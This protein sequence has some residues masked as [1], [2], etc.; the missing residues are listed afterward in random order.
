MA[1][2]I[3]QLA[4]SWLIIWLVEKQ[5]LNVLGFKPTKQRAA[6]FLLFLLVAA[7]CCASGFL[8][9]MWFGNERWEVNPK[10]NAAFVWEGIWWNIKSVLFEELIFR[11]VLFYILIK[12]VGVV[13]GIIVSSVAFGIYH[14]FSY[15]ILGNIP[16]MAIYF[17]VTGIMG[18]VY[19]YGYAKTFSLYI[20]AAIHFGWNFTQSFV[21]SKGPIG[22]GILI[23]AKEQTP[24]TVSGVIYTLIFLLPIVSVWV[25]CYVLIK[26]KKQVVLPGTT[27][28]IFQTG[29]LYNRAQNK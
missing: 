11:G 1:G 22:N 23:M 7:L 26:N 2:I 4:I 6:D 28:S 17:F 25:V 20:P 9:R 21:F 8:L 19:A 12:W 24:V 3:V 15:G 18:L 16:Q 5:H 13:K 27:A 29:R 10:I 14:W